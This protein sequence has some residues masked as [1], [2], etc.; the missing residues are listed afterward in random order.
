MLAEARTNLEA[1]L[2]QAQPEVRVAFEAMLRADQA[3]ASA[4]DAARLAAAGV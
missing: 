2:R 1:A 4:R 3:L